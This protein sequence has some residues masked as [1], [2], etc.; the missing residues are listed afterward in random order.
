M[1]QEIKSFGRELGFGKWP[2]LLVI[3]LTRAFTEPPRPLAAEASDLIA[4]VNML[5]GG[6]RARQVPVMFTRVVYEMHDLSDAG[7]WGYKIGGQEDLSVGSDGIEIDPRLDR[8]AH[9][10]VLDKKYASC[11]FATDLASRLTAKGHDTIII[12]GVT[13]SGC[14]RATAVD[15]IQSGFRPFVVSDGVQDRWADAHEQSLKDLQ[16]KYAEVVSGDSVLEYLA[17]LPMSE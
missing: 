3:D 11:F 12:T 10:A 7:V 16:A 1:S 2:L 15:A 17:K 6:A 4:R 5:V 9:D 13:T 14:V 8:D